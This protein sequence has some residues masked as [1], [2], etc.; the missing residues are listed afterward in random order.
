MDTGVG[1]G[2][3]EVGRSGGKGVL[4]S[5]T[6]KLFK[7]FYRVNYF[8]GFWDVTGMEGHKWSGAGVA[9]SCAEPAEQVFI[10]FYFVARAS[11][12]VLELV[13]MAHPITVDLDPTGIKTGDDGIFLWR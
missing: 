4:S 1:S 6:K 5:T 11:R 13:V 8:G 3:R 12:L 2:L 10:L 9:G 7:P